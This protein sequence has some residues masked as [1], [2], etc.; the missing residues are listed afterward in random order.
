M[1]SP[2]SPN[3]APIVQFTNVS[4]SFGDSK[5]VN[6][7]SFEIRKGEFFSLLGPSGCGKT[8][9]LRLLAGF[10]Q[11][12]ADGGTV[13]IDSQVVNQKRPYERQIGMVFQNYAIF[14]HLSVEKNVA[15]GLEQHNVPK[16]EIPDRVVKAMEMVRLDPTRFARRTQP[17]S[18]ALRRTEA[19]TEAG[20]ARSGSQ[21]SAFARASSTALPNRAARISRTWA[22]GMAMASSGRRP[23]TKEESPAR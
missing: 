3:D 22:G 21:V 1:A 12:D 11:P 20:I 13:K 9:T 17:A 23:G 6:N 10:E 2:V 7:I 18:G 19:P 14:P 5:A 4:K 15:F 8:T 16:A